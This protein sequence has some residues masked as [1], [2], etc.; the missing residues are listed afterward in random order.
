[1][2]SGPITAWE[3]LQ[4]VTDF[5]FWGSKILGDGDYSHEVR[6]LLLGRRVMTNLDR[7][8]WK[9]R[10]YSAD[11]GL[12]SQGYGLPSGHIRLW[13]LDHEEGRALNNWCLWTVVLEKTP[14]SPLDSKEIKP[15]NLK[16]DQ[17]WIFTVR[18]DAEAE[19]PVFWSSDANRQLIGKVPDARKVWRQKKRIVR[20]WVGWM[21][22][23]MQWTRTWANSRRWWGIGKPGVLLFMGSQR[24]GN[25][26]VAEQQIIQN[27]IKP[28]F[29]LLI[30]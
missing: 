7:V 12:Y 6:W 21:A 2:A 22:S 10:H 1:M 14:E 9:Q 23:L 15:D 28:H 19:A 5:L 26:L 24:V 4:V 29:Y 8:S 3:K 11:S 20:G 30:V 18:T 16:G 13:E 17:P 25:N 27:V